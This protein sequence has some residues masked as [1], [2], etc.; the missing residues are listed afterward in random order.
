MILKEIFKKPR[1]IGRYALLF[2]IFLGGCATTNTVRHAFG[3]DLID[4]N[5]AVEIVDWRYGESRNYGAHPL[6]EQT[7]TKRI[8]VIGELRY[9]NLLY[10]KWRNTTTNT[11]Y[12]ET[13]DL[14]TRLPK[15]ITDH[16]IH[17]SIIE[18]QLFVYLMTPKLRPPEWPIYP[19]AYSRIYKTYQIY[20]DNK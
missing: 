15:D 3:F 8:N 12:A 10:V 17:V 1:N 18:D 20:P 2:S 5:P 13:V 4:E 14:K 9:P 19:P 11:V 7:A 16:R 6:P